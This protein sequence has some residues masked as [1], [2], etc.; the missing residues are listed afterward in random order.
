MK[1]AKNI[2]PNLAQRF[3]RWFLRDDLAE[4]VQGD[5]EEQ[6]D[7][8]VM[9]T[10]LVRAKINYWYQ[11]FNYL[12]PFAIGKS[13]YTNTNHIAMFKHNFVITFRNFRRN[14]TTFL[15]N[16]LGLP[17]GMACALLIYLWVHDELSVDKFH[18]KS[19]RLYEIMEN[20]VQDGKIITRRST[21]A[22]MSQ[23]LA[24]E[25][26]E[27]EYAVTIN[28]GRDILYKVLSVNEKDI[29]STG[30]YADSDFFRMFTFPLVEGDPGK[31]LTDNQS[32]V[33]SEKLSKSLFGSADDAMGKMISLEHKKTYMV[34]G[35]M[36]NIPVRSSLRF[37]FVLPMDGFRAENNFANT[38]YNT[39]PYTFVLFRPGADATAFNRKIKDLVKT[40]TGGE[41]NHRTPFATR[42]SDFYLHGH[43]VNGVQSGGRIEY[44][45]LFSIIAVLILL[46]ASINFMNMTTARAS[47]RMKEIGIKKT[48]GAGRKILIIQYLGESLILSFLSL[49]VAVLLVIL[50]L[51]EFNLLTGKYLIYC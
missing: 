40:K 47:T 32:I 2:P 11:V 16:M 9:K 19:D 17:A 38:W 23:A 4:E 31:A 35:I 7:D 41:A 51:P 29:E 39:Y 3:L 34:S 43:Y 10:S 13:T 26:P 49:T 12:R 36:K 50:L 30:I 22:P 48:I 15:I 46:I 42:F 20:V 33:I 8:M 21:A 27:V 28:P 45:K 1:K 14:K 18:T 25:M 5:L 37:D 44:V 6:F 24:E